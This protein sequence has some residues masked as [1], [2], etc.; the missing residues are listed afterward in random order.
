MRTAGASTYCLGYYVLH[1]DACIRG[2]V[3]GEMHTD[4]LLT[5]PCAASVGLGKKCAFF[6]KIKN[7]KESPSRSVEVLFCLLTRAPY[8][9]G[10][11]G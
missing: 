8:N 3:G 7:K 4:T 5:H 9:V 2:V 6:K 10:S 1:Q 11:T